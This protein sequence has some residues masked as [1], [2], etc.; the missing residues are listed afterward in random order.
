MIV[1]TLRKIF[2]DTKKM[3]YGRATVIDYIGGYSHP[4]V[5]YKYR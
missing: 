4:L 5:F 1:A 2:W 3:S